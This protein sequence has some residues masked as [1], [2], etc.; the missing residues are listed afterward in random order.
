MSA[1]T[2]RAPAIATELPVAA[3]V[4]DGTITSASSGRPLASV[5][6]CWADVPELTATA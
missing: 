3:K 2:G 4:K 6:R 5:A 1:K